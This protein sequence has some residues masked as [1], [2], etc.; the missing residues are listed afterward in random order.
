MESSASSESLE[1]EDKILGKSRF[2]VLEQLKKD[3]TVLQFSVL[4]ANYERLTLVTGLK[5]GSDGP[6]VLLDC[7]LGFTETITDFAGAG[8]KVEFVGKDKIQYTF[9]SHI[10]TV[11]DRDISIAF[12]EFIARI[13]RRR[14]F[15]I[16]P[17][18]GTK[19]VFTKDG[20]VLE[21]SVINLSEGGSLLSLP[22][23]SSREQRIAAGDYLSSLRFLCQ[24]EYAKTEIG[25]K[26][27]LVKRAE[28]DLQTGRFVFA[29]QFTELEKRNNHTLHEY[30]FRC[31]REML[32]RRSV[33][34]ES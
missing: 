19:V 10:R 12:P 24:G 31:Q 8:V 32:Q 3:R 20:K 11:S 25:V 16:A 33:L 22:G 4:G 9:R 2:T 29:L 28:K 1:S 23:S 7:P 6:Y 34:E 14:Y 13:Q 17:P 18:I 5:G 30:I 21:A 27:A 26:K 15:R